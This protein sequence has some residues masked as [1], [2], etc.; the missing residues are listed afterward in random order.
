MGISYVKATAETGDYGSGGGAPTGATDAIKVNSIDYT[1]DR[2]AMREETTDSYTTNEII[3]GALKI[4]GSIDTNFR[5]TSQAPLLASCFGT[6]VAGV[7]DIEEPTSA[8]LAIG[9]KVGSSTKERLLYGVGVKSV[10]FTFESKEY[11]KAK[12]DFIACDIVDGTYDTTLSYPAE[13]PLVFWGATLDLSATTLYSKS[14]T[15]T[16]DRALDEEQFVLGNYKL[17]RLT[18][19]GVTDISGSLTITEEQIA[20]MNRAIYGTTGGS[21]MPALNTLGE[22]T[23]TIDCMRTSGA[24][25]ATFVIPVTYETSSFSSSGVGELEKSIEFSVVGNPATFLT[26]A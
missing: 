6:A 17:Y 16:V 19:T 3:G 25:G 15:L 9:E 11:V 24:A 10:E 1:V 20:E 7:Y 13:D 18:R 22:G 26:V 12:Y 2:G 21:A 14:V 4:S 23:L 8:C 5:P